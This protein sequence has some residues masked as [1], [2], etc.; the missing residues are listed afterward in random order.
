MQ[1]DDTADDD[2]GRRLRL[3]ALGDAG[4]Y[5]VWTT[6]HPVGA[7]RSPEICAIRRPCPPA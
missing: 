1:A 4:V 5:H 3:P 6:P 7:V 2:Q